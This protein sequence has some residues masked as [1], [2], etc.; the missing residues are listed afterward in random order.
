MVFNLNYKDGVKI[1]MAYIFNS[2]DL[3]LFIKRL[4]NCIY[5]EIMKGLL[6]ML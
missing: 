5:Y 6:E 1:K 2:F 4:I 3:E